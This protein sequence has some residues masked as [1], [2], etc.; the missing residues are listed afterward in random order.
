VPTMKHEKG[1]DFLRFM[2][3]SLRLRMNALRLYSSNMASSLSR[4]RVATEAGRGKAPVD[5]EPAPVASKLSRSKEGSKD[6]KPSEGSKRGRVVARTIS[7]DE[8]DRFA[9]RSKSREP[10]KGPSSRGVVPKADG[11][12]G[13]KRGSSLAASKPPVALMSQHTVMSSVSYAIGPS[14][15]AIIVPDAVV[16]HRLGVDEAAERLHKLRDDA[17]DFDNPPIPVAA[18][19]HI[20]AA[21]ARAVGGFAA[22]D[23]TPADFD[24]V[25][26]YIA[27]RP[28]SGIRPRS[29]VRTTAVNPALAAIRNSGNIAV[30][31]AAGS[32]SHAVKRSPVASAHHDDYSD[33]GKLQE[34]EPPPSRGTASHSRSSKR[35]NVTRGMEPLAGLSA[36]PAV[37]NVGVSY[38]PLGTFGASHRDE[39]AD[40]QAKLAAD[41][42]DGHSVPAPKVCCHFD[43]QCVLSS[44][45]C[46]SA[47]G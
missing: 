10:S 15:A 19:A 23:D 4:Q 3:I 14:G 36:L 37:G 20:H 29:G 24:V 32:S 16:R 43:C 39:A 2:F 40:R 38:P 30:S 22:A 33:A 21:A 26:H 45:M 44:R 35:T 13:T 47:A 41:R 27:T 42:D 1:Q 31:S 8:K 34:D 18:S 11:K 25:E 46:E 28:T 17:D 5:P 6:S 12:D 9:D 7:V